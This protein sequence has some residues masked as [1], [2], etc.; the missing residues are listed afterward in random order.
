MKKNLFIIGMIF[1]SHLI[2]SQ[3]IDL[4]EL[5]T[6]VESPEKV[7]LTIDSEEIK[8]ST[9]GNV[10]D[11]LRE[12]GLLIMSTGGSGT[13]SNFSFKGYAGFCCKVYVD[14]V[15]ATQPGT[16]EFDWNSIDINSIESITV[17]EIPSVS[18]D[19]FAGCVVYIRTRL[20]SARGFDVKT[21]VTSY[22][23]SFADTASLFGEYR[24]VIGNTGFKINAQLNKADNE[25]LTAKEKI[26]RDN[27]SRLG[28]I[29]ASFNTIL[30]DNFTI[31]GTSKFFYNQLKA[32]GTGSDRNVGIEEDLNAFNTVKARY[33]TENLAVLQ[34]NLTAQYNQIDYDQTR[35]QHDKTRMHT[36]D[37]LLTAE[38]YYGF[39]LSSVF[40]LENKISGNKEQR[41]HNTT[42][43]SYEFEPSEWIK[44][45]PSAGILISSEN[46]FI[47]LPQIT[48]A[49]KKIGLSASAFRQF[50]LPTFN[51]LYWEGGG[52]KGN[53]DLN[54]EDG[55]SLVTSW[56]SPF[57]FL[58]VSLTYTFA[59]YGNK[60]RWGSKNGVLMPMNTVSADYRTFEARFSKDFKYAGFNAGFTNTKALLE[61]GHQ[62]MWVPEW[63]YNL[64]VTVHLPAKI[65]LGASYIYTGKRPEDNWN[66][67]YYDEIK[68]L[69]LS[70]KW[71][72][73][74]RSTILFE[75]KNLMDERHYY[76]DSYPM[77]G[78]SFTV[79]Y[80]FRG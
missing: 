40:S 23:T 25:Y 4:G 7:E 48:I 16:G 60:I 56:K 74:T 50:V 62:I 49:S 79:G 34:A 10:P 6:I 8:N 52:G 57:T 46:D 20:V 69:Q 43:L 1:I 53:P 58:P 73:T 54:P 64:G 38:N 37:L 42:K 31:S 70:L 47:F 51:Q 9:A 18:T 32:F 67:Y 39:N 72:P 13:Q 28:N 63:Q 29:S 80:M 22:G 33:V 35:T 78:R 2:F 26:L 21:L 11:L 45:V 27:W 68:D 15:L 19:Q 71:Q 76:H 17:S 3:N 14:G 24:D 5:V 44:I 41:F 65:D 77:P 75:V 66:L 12:K 30:A 36:A 61:D 59:K 55:W